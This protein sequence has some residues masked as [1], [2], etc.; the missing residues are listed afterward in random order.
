M[1]NAKDCRGHFI[2][3]AERGKAHLECRG[4]ILSEKGR[5]HAVPELKE[6]IRELESNPEKS[7]D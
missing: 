1:K 5:I 4:L 3:E 7:G 6:K 2:G